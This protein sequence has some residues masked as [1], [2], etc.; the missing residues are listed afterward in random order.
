MIERF[1]T[2]PS[3][4][5]ISEFIRVN[6]DKN[7]DLQMLR[8]V[9]ESTELY[10]LLEILPYF[11]RNCIRYFFK[12]LPISNIRHENPNLTVVFEMNKHEDSKTGILDIAIYPISLLISNF[13]ISSIIS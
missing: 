7:N 2:G 11:L 8:E 6:F 1:I 5:H 13:G 4:I 9:V 3:S 10:F 12:D